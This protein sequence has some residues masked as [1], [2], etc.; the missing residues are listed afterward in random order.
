[1]VSHDTVSLAGSVTGADRG[2]L[3]ARSQ[4]RQQHRSGLVMIYIGQ[5][6]GVELRFPSP[7][8][9]IVTRQPVLGVHELPFVAQMAPSIEG[10]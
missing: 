5:R 7:P 9:A 1:M 3:A 8:A 10:N 4:Q 2:V 6:P